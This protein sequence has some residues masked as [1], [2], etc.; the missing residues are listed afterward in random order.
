MLYILAD[1]IYALIRAFWVREYGQ[2][3]SHRMDYPPVRWFKE[4]ITK[5]PYKGTTLDKTKFDTL[6]D[7]YYAKRGWDSRGIPT[8]STFEKL[9]LKDAADQLSRK[10]ALTP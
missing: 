5:G 4:P 9:G 1:R 2:E 6:L 8:Q 10:V 7:M 3:W